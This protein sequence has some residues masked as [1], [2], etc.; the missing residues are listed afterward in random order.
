[1]N[2]EYLNN[3]NKT[4]SLKLAFYET[5]ISSNI[6][7]VN[8]AF[9]IINEK[10]QAASVNGCYRIGIFKAKETYNGI[11]SW[12]PQIYNEIKKLNHIPNMI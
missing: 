10:K 1:M 11:K 7:I 4:I 3:T 12:L 9:S 2:R 8:L 6:K 5:K